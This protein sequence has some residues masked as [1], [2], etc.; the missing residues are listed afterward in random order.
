MFVRLVDVHE[1]ALLKALGRGVVFF[2]GDVA[3]GFVDEF[4]GTVETAAPIEAGVNCGMIVE[5]LAVV[6]G[7]LFDFVDGLIDFVNGFLF[8]LAQFAAI[9]VL[10]MGACMAEI[11]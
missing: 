1:G 2:L 4:E 9:G 8:L 7:G 5:I 6:D 11:G 10:Q 3:V